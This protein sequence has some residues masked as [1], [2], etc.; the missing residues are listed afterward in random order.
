MLTRDNC[1]PPGDILLKLEVRVIGELIIIGLG[2]G[3]PEW[4]TKEA[5]EVIQS[6]DEIFL[7][8]IDHPV[9]S[10]LPKTLSLNGFDHFYEEAE[11][12]DEV[13]SRIVERILLEVTRRKRTIY[14]VPGD[15]CVGEATVSALRKGLIE[16]EVQLKIIPGVSFIE[17]CLAMLEID[18][19]DALSV[20][21]A[22]SVATGHHPPF[23]PDQSVMIAQLYSKMVASDVKLTLMNQYPD[24]HPT[25]LLHS[26]GTPQSRIEEYPLYEIDQS[27]NIGSMTTLYIP[28]LS[29]PSSLES[30]QDT[31]AHLRAPDG[32][33]WDQEQ[34]HESLRMHLLEES[35]EVLH[36]IDIG[37]L[38]ALQEELGDLLLQIILHAQ[39]AT[40]AG[41]FTMADVIAGINS[42]IIRRHPHVFDKLDLKGVDQVL[43]NWE[44]LKAIEREKEGT[45]RGVLDGVPQGLPALAQAYELQSRVGRVGF[46]WPELEGVLAKIA[47]ELQEVSEAEDPLSEAAEIGDLLFA[48]VN[49]ARWLDVDP[50]TAL[51][52][53]NRRFRTR[54]AH[55]EKEAAA[56]GCDLSEMTLEEMDSLWEAVKENPQ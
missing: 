37:N 6:A 24:D 52:E 1:I 9:V 35:Y 10:E 45:D 8:T 26:A 27:D 11:D 50:E 38:D 32:C 46:D 36:A 55:L 2:P 44:K 29:V 14:A 51:R 40:E 20:V 3:A 21:D 33:P 42:K 49:Y 43:S 56:Q 48:V 23:S 5:W 12:F 30:F 34:T 7:R 53:A 28:P 4:M 39:I 31:V 47:E 17:P 25:K 16:S 13:Y 18:A 41:E 15:P 19:L 22:L 54:F